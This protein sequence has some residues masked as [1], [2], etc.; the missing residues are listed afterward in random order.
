MDWATT[1]N[2][3]IRGHTLCW[4]SQLPGWVSGLSATAMEAALKNHIT[5]EMTKW[6]GQIYAW[7]V[8][9]EVLTEQGALDSSQPF[10]KT[11]GEKFIKIAFDTARAT[12]PNAKLYINDYNLD[13]GTYA[14]TTGMANLVKK[15]IGQGIPI[16]GIGM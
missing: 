6:K 1:N 16:D 4:H 13:S 11:M 3:T 10:M 9:N 15:W 2:K 7:D 8:V 14:K 5:T 12:D